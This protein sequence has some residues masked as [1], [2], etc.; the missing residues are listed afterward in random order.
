M[1]FYSDSHCRIKDWLMQSLCMNC[2]DPYLFRVLLVSLVGMEFLD[3][4]ETLERGG[5]LVSLVWMD[6]L[7]VVMCMCVCMY[8]S[9]HLY[10]VVV[11]PWESGTRCMVKCYLPKV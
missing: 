5:H 11:R 4:R 9:Y 8:V 7:Y 2:D 3:L 1:L 6:L 10:I